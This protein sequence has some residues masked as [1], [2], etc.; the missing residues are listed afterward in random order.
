MCQSYYVVAALL[1]ASM[2]VLT[3]SW[4]IGL[5]S[6]FVLVL[7]ALRTPKAE[8]MLIDRFGEPY[9]DDMMRTGRF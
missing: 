7:L 1:M 9:R 8:Q 5:S 3:A 4:L 6:L 2:T